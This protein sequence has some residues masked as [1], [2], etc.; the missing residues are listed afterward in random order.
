MNS[1][2][3]PDEETE[4]SLE[5]FTRYFTLDEMKGFMRQKIQER[6][7]Q[8]QSQ[9]ETSTESAWDHYFKDG[10]SI[11]PSFD[12]RSFKRKFNELL[13]YEVAEMIQ[14][15]LKNNYSKVQEQVEAKVKEEMEEYKLE[16]KIN[17]H[18]YITSKRADTKFVIIEPDHIYD[19]KRHEDED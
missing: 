7:K 2:N 12:S 19:E 6:I 13:E 3:T 17:F 5:E 1:T 10:D 11:Y 14:T 15:W 16:F 18:A 8:Y 9:I 4:Q